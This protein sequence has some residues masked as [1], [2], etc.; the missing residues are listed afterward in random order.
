MQYIFKRNILVKELLRTQVSRTMIGL[1][2]V[3]V[4]NTHK[5]VHIYG[6]CENNK[7][8]YILPL[9]SRGNL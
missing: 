6:A 5:A 8:T 3:N 4:K 1:T 9:Q 7:D 2:S